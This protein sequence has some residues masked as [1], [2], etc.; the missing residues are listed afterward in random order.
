M[1]DF[2]DKQRCWH[3]VLKNGELLSC[4]HYRSVPTSFVLDILQNFVN[5]MCIIHVILINNRIKVHVS[6]GREVVP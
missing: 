4:W 2:D 1:Y 3:N 5:H 6:Y